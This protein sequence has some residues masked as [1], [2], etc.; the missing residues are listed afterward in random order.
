MTAAVIPFPARRSAPLGGPRVQR[1]LNETLQAAFAAAQ[2]EDAD[3]DAVARLADLVADPAWDDAD[4]SA[5]LARLQPA[6]RWIDEA[7]GDAWAAA[8]ADEGGWTTLSGSYA[9]ER[10]Q[11][12]ATAQARLGEAAETLRRRSGPGAP[13]LDRRAAA[14]GLMD[15]GLDEIE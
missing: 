14:R 13:E 7:A 12:L 4:A 2:G 10:A 3:L 8:L 1:A 6:A 15:V 5:V 9:L 11:G